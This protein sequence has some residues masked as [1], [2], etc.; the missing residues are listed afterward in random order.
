MQRNWFWPSANWAGT[1]ASDKDY[2]ELPLVLRNH[3]LGKLRISHSMSC[4]HY[5]G[6]FFDTD[7]IQ[8]NR[9]HAWQCEKYFLTVG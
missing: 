4:A 9:E 8:E 6:S 2:K 7:Q 5:K 1:R 3:T